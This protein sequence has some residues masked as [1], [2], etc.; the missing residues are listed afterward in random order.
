MLAQ[1]ALGANLSRPD[2]TAPRETLGAALAA[3]EAAG[4]AVRSRSDWYRTPAFPPGSG[5]DFV[6][7]AATVATS[8]TPQTFLEDLHAIEAGFGRERDRRWAPR[9]CDLDLIAADDLVLPDPKTVSRWMELPPEDRSL[10]PP[11]LM[12]PHPRLHERP[13]VLVPLAQIAPDW[14]HPL[15]G[16]TVRELYDA[17]PPE[18][19][20]AIVRL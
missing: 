2:G 19:R 17:L 3:L 16:R 9:A 1:I 20:D 12:L 15:L 5:P 8:A 10:P 18:E 4:H 11:V 13:F 6:N 14:R 7:G